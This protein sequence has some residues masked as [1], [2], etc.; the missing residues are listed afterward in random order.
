MKD[1][2]SIGPEI[3]AIDSGYLRPRMDALH[4]IAHGGRAAI[5]E[6]G[7]AH[8]VPRVIAALAEAGMVPEQVDW[9]LLTHVHLDHAGGAGALLQVLPNARL[10]VHPRGVRHMIDPRKLW[11]GTVAVYGDAFARQAYGE[12]VPVDASRVVEGADGMVIDL[13]GRA[14]E[15][16][17]A[18][19]HAKHHLC[20][21]DEQSRGW[22]TGDAFGLSYRETH[23]GERAFVFPTTTPVQ[24]DPVAMHATVERM[25]AR[26]PEAMFLTHYSRV[27]QVPRLAA[28][29]HR[30]IDACVEVAEAA[31]NV[32]GDSRRLLIR[33]ALETMLRQEAAG[34]GW[35][36][37]GNAA[38]ALYA[39]DLDLNAQGLQTWLEG[40][41]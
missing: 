19:G 25:L 12:L 16:L 24:F 15:V 1:I 13:A 36:V 2:E 22:F 23:R 35:A 9:L 38:V 30:L 3:W 37:Q 4:L 11:E 26:Q 40:R 33:A 31:A 5:V 28:D 20:Y 27:T 41:Q 6:S 29:L 10:V 17:D 14:I 34:Q 18:P 7:T 21:F 8:S 39:T 32:E